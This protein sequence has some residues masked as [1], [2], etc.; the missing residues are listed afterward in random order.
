MDTSFILEESSVTNKEI[1]RQILIQNNLNNRFLKKLSRLNLVSR[2]TY[3]DV[4]V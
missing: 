1:E 3:H 4:G 2:K